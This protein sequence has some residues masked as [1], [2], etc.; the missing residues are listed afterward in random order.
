MFSDLKPYPEYSHADEG[1]I[2]SIP[3]GWSIARFKHAFREIVGGATP[4]S[5]DALNWNGPVVWVTPS[6]VSR[7]SLLRSSIRTLTVRGFESCA[8]TLVPAGSVILT[9]RAPVGNVAV[10]RVPLVTNQG[11]K[12][13]VPNE[14]K[15]CTGFAAR[16]IEAMRSEIRS[17]AVGTTFA[18]I[19]T[20]SLGACRMPLPPRG[21]QAAIVKYLGHAHLRID[22]AIA[23]KRRLIALLDEE[24]R[25]VIEAAV[26]RGLD[27]TVPL[28]DSGEAGLGRIPTHWSI[29]RLKDV[30]AN[31]NSRR[32]PLSSEQRGKML[33]REYD[34]YG[35]SGVIDR[36]DDFLF[37]EPTILIAEDGANLNSRNLPLAILASGRYWVNNHAHILRPRTGSI[38]FLAHRL[39]LINYQPWISGSAQPKLTKDRLMAIRIAIPGPAEQAEIA[40]FLRER[41]SVSRDLALRAGKEIGLLREF[42]T[43][44]TADVVTGQLDVRAAAARLPDLDPADLAS[45]VVGQDEDDLD[46]EAAEF[47]EDVDA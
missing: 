24:D 6:D 12:A 14:A 19:S 34:Y 33:S 42:R 13:L 39:E 5:S 40:E 29:C 23:A 21:D 45:D 1:W 10:A 32:V 25:I 4:S 30:F 22:R 20:S 3:T 35:A 9:T 38:E 8:T 7:T 41:L 15:I 31:L 26:T 47:L 28:I 17:L 11:C 2:E 37:D 36:V 16:M 43:R 46:T 44:L 18:E 27:P